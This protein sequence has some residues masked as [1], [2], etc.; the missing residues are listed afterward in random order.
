MPFAV[1]TLAAAGCPVL[2]NPRDSLQWLTV[3]RKKL[4]NQSVSRII[5]LQSL[6]QCEQHQPFTKAR[7]CC[8]ASFFRGVVA[9]WAIREPL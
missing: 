7:T 2:A 8:R 6:R 9:L 3:P 5:S 1:E 4:M